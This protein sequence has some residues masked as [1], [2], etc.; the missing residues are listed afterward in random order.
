MKILDFFKNFAGGNFHMNKNIR[1]LESRMLYL[2]AEL[3]LVFERFYL[4]IE[5]LSMSC[6]ARTIL[7]EKLFETPA[8][9]LQGFQV[10]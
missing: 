7:N 6:P 2:A 3:L 5:L 9:T 10:F 4:L 8:I 1:H